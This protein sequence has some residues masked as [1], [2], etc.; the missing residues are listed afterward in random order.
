MKKQFFNRGLYLEGLRQLKLIGILMTVIFSVVAIIPPVG[1][2]ILSLRQVP[3]IQ[4]YQPDYIPTPE[5]VDG[6]LMNPA[7]IAVFLVIAPV[8]VFILFGFLNK[9]KSSDFYH[10]IPHTRLSIFLSFYGAVMTWVAIMI[11][12]SSV[13]A[14]ISYAIFPQF[15][16]PQYSALLLFILTCFVISTLVVGASL[17][18]VSLSGTTA[19]NVLLTLLIL[20]LPRITLTTLN[21]ALMSS[22][23]ILPSGH[24]FPLLDNSYNLLFHFLSNFFNGKLFRGNQMIKSMTSVH[25]LIYTAVL[26]VIFTVLAAI[27]FICRKSESAERSAPSKRLQATY[28]IIVTMIVCLFA[29]MSIFYLT[30]SK[31]YN[32][33]S[34]VFGI[35]VLYIVALIVYFAYELISTRKWKN[36]L[37]ALPGLGIVAVLNVAI[38]GLL[39]GLR[40]S[41][42]SFTPDADEIKSISVISTDESNH[43]DYYLSEYSFY[44]YIQT[45]M[46]TIQLDTPESKEIIVA[47][48]SDC[49]KILKENGTNYYREGINNSDYKNPITVKISTATGNHYRTVYVTPKD[50]NLIANQL[51][52]DQ[53]YL[54]LYMTIPKPIARYGS[55]SD[56]YVRGNGWKNFYPSSNKEGENLLNTLQEEITAMGF[57]KWFQ[58]VS[59]FSSY[60][61]SIAYVYYTVE[62]GETI[63]I[64]I[65]AV[66][67]PQTYKLYLSMSA[68]TNPDNVLKALEKTTTESPIYISANFTVYLINPD[69]GKIQ[70][71][72]F[73]HN[74][75]NI[76]FS[77]KKQ[78]DNVVKE[79]SNKVCSDK[80]V[81]GNIFWKLSFDA[82]YQD[83]YESYRSDYANDT[84][85][86][87]HITEEDLLSLGFTT[88]NILDQDQVY[89]D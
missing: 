33:D 69:T 70:P 78:Y 5:K 60:S 6:V 41:S 7:I 2:G 86:L 1:A 16:F 15:F 19:T 77:S 9:R 12:T 65:N 14:I 62:S 47:S 35:V 26:A 20:Y 24:G 39:G 22:L 64:P 83:E 42:L 28:R 34:E 23:P 56:I 63:F 59:D 48:L 72:Y 81:Q 49:V 85:C 66:D 61:D 38:L 74:T 37:R 89:Y 84:V 29:C 68:N 43:D 58:W 3:E 40:A 45:Q 79:L 54:D 71:Y 4:K 51:S 67:M 73:R 27:L 50:F 18:A 30:H 76:N 75:D 57:D 17:I 25:G 36:L 44:A 52:N 32:I 31:H 11:V 80:N 82:T 10:A 53:Q 46:H 8:M 13:C 55:R 21:T 87:S 88:E